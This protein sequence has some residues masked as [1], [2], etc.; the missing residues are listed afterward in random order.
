METSRNFSKSKGLGLAD[1][2]FEQ[3]RHLV[4]NKMER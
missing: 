2:M 4:E 1:A 3:L